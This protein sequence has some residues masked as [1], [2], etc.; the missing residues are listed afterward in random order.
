[1]FTNVQ[2]RKALSDKLFG[3]LTVHLKVIVEII[4]ACVYKYF[5]FYS[6]QINI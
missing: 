2:S 5:R 1:M 4:C 3:I 6:D